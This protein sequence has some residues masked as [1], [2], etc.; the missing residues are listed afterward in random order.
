MKRPT[1]GIRKAESRD[2]A[3][4]PALVV[5]D[6]VSFH[7]S[8]GIPFRRSPYDVGAGINGRSVRVSLSRIHLL[9]C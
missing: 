3:L 1:Y 9:S 7:I 2:E 6:L 8:N 5:Y 4:A